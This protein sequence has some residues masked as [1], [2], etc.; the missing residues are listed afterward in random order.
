MIFKLDVKIMAVLSRKNHAE[1][2]LL[3][4]PEASIIYD[5]R[6]LNGGGDAWYNAKRIWTADAD[7]THRLVLQDDAILCDDFLRYVEKCIAFNP[8]CV[9][10]F[11]AGWKAEQ[12]FKPSPHT[13][14]VRIRGCKTSGQA[15]LMPIGYAKDMVID[16]DIAFGTDYKHDD[17]RIGWWCAYNG[18]DVFGTNPQ[19]V[20]HKQIKS[21]LKYHNAVR[22]SRTFRNNVS[23]LNW[24]AQTFT[25]TPIIFPHLWTDNPRAIAYCEVAKEKI[26][27]RQ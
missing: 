3:H 21:T 22:Y 16:T 27:C 7:C 10:T 2:L 5:D 23:D 15:V 1:E 19:L 4:I 17:S 26:K 20:D 25:D 8:S 24:D 14:Y 18:I 11:H 6:G 12:K 13:P 9:W